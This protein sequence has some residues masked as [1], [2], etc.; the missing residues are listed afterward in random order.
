[1]F[2]GYL[3]ASGTG[4]VPL[5]QCTAPLPEADPRLT[6]LPRDVPFV[7]V[8]SESDFNRVAAQRRADSDA[9]ADVFRLYEIAAGSHFGPYPAGMPTAG[10]LAIAGLGLPIDGLCIEPASDYPMGLAFNAI[11]QQ[12]SDWLAA[13]VPMAS[14][15]RIETNAANEPLRDAN[16]NAIGGWRLPQ[17]D[18]PL[19]AYA[20]SA[21]ARENSDRARAACRLT[22]VKLP[23]TALQL[24]TMYGRP[25]G[26]LNLLRAAAELAVSERRL[27]PEDG[28]ALESLSANDLPQF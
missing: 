5:N 28:E 21:T 10:D 9:P 26:Y 1:V 11:W 3:A 12:Y 25:A 18:L 20:G 2:D 15:P 16:G 14:V 19:A 7:S 27:T 24:K 4:A 13:G 6:V 8:M 17:L 22:G 23:L